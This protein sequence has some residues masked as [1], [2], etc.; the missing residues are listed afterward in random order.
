MVG[1]GYDAHAERLQNH[2]HKK[3]DY[4]C[5]LKISL[6]DYFAKNYKISTLYQYST[7]SELARFFSAPYRI[8]PQQTVLKRLVLLILIYPIARNIPYHK[9]LSFHALI[10]SSSLTC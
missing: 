3:K 5:L 2:I 1:N 10:Q 4:L 8:T 7:E 9:I 6:E